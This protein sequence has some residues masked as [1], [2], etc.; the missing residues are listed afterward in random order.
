MREKPLP[1]EH[2]LTADPFLAVGH[3]LGCIIHRVFLCPQTGNLVQK[4]AY[5]N[6]QR[7]MRLFKLIYKVFMQ[8]F[9][10][11]FKVMSSW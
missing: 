8:N 11:P 5:A 2:P 1:V 9:P 10:S 3:L 6:T 7:L 4:M